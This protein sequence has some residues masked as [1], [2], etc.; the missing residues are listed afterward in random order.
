MAEVFN[1]STKKRA[2]EVC[3]TK[4]FIKDKMTGRVD[5]RYTNLSKLQKTIKL[6]SQEPKK[7]NF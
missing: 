6:K 4:K 2:I 7:H 1:F 3:A 5:T